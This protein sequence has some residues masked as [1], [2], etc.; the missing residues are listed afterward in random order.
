MDEDDGRNP[1]KKQPADADAAAGRPEGSRRVAGAAAAPP[2]ERP[3]RGRRVLTRNELE[4]L[5]SRLQKKFH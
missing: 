4:T 1:K 2:A 5:R 3:E